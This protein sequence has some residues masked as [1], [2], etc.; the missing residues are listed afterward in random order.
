MTTL[1]YEDGRRALVSVNHENITGDQ[2]ARFRV[3]GSAG[4]VRGTIG[5]LYDYPHGR[6]DT[7]EV[8]STLLPTDGWLPY[9]VTTRWIPDA[10]AGPMRALLAEITD[11]TPAPT[12]GADSLQTLRLVEAA[13]ASIETGDAEPVVVS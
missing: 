9:P 2:V 5:L 3:D 10:F 11:D 4:S 1:V 6:P 8:N 7:L 12:S 13:Y